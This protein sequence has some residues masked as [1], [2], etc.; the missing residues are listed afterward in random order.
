MI[1]NS[2]AFSLFLP[3]VFILYWFLFNKS[4]KKQNILLLSASL[5]FYGWADWRFLFLVIMNALLNYYIGTGISNTQKEKIKKRLLWLGLLINLGVLGY[6]KYF[7]FFYDSFA[8]LFNLFGANLNYSSLKIILP[9]GISFFTFQTL[10][11]IID[12]YNEEIE[13]YRDLL[14]FTTYV[15]YFPK[16]LSGPIERAQKFIP[17]IEVR[18]NFDYQLAN[19]G[20]RQILWGLFA[21]I[22]VAD[23]CAALV[24]NIF[25]N[26]QNQSGSMLLLGSFCYLIQIYC[27]FSGYSN[28]AIGIS[29]LFGIKLM[30]NFAT[31][32]FSTNIGDFWKKW[33]ISLTTWMMD[34]VFTPLSFILR[35]Y[36]KKGLILSIITTFVIVGL[37]HGANWTFIVFGLLQG[38][39]FIPLIFKGN[40]NQPSS[41]APTNLL[42]SLKYFFQMIGLFFLLMLTAVFFRSESVG[43]AVEY[44]SNIFSTS[45]FVRPDIEQIIFILPIIIFFL[46]IEWISKD[47][48]HAMQFDN[49]SVYIAWSAYLIIGFIVVLSF[50]SNNS[51]FIY[52]QF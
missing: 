51:S 11:Y 35:K 45:L 19:D 39:Y 12:V 20:L 44:L 5:F 46:I 37:W 2:L 26:Y 52:L 17:Q 32:F 40:L 27:D 21:K 9:L 18:R 6:F 22:V 30:M 29:K 41:N 7:N 14:V 38:L 4:A 1:F 42:P 50:K 23:N 47:K 49:H 10:G 34:Y 8:D 3:I 36:K 33:H 28:M 43:Q 15:T 16:I 31:P 24:N 25:D 48:Q 13:P